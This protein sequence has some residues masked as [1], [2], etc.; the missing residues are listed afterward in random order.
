MATSS[1]YLKQPV[2]ERL[3]RLARTAEDI[4]AAIHGFDSAVLSRRPARDSLAA[5]EVVCHLRDIEE[6]CILRYHAMLCMDEPKLFAV[7]VTAPE[8]EDWGIIAGLPYPL[9]ADRWAEERQYL[10]N[11]AG[12]A[13]SAFRRRRGE[14]LTLLRALSSDQWE[15]A[16]L[17]P[18]TGRV[19]FNRFTAVIAAHD[20]NHLDQL[21]RALEGRA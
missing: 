21:Q 3:N 11:D 8:P 5:I 7:G 12:E 2:D 14:T 19:T 6:L 1:D 16:A 20:D 17:I 9:D 18:S 10:R 4:A 15:R 13:H